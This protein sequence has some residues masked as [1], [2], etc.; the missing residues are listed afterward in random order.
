MATVTSQSSSGAAAPWRVA[1]LGGVDSTVLP[2]LVTVAT[3]LA[4]AL[5]AGAAYAGYAASVAALG[6]LGLALALGWPRALDG[7]SLPG[8]RVVL[9][10]GVLL[11]AGTM[12]AT[13]TDPRLTWLPVALAFATIGALLHQLLR[14]RDRSRLSDGM[15]AS[16]SGLAV[17][18]SGL[19][20]AA[21]AVR[22]HGPGFVLVGLVALAVGAVVELLG[23]HPRIRGLAVLPV[24]VAGGLAG[25]VTASA[26][27]GVKSGVALGLGVMVA[28]FSYSVRRVFGATRRIVEPSVQ[29][30]VAAS[31]VLLPGVLLLVMG[32][33]SAV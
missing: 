8:L 3:L 25:L 19:T 33:L 14:R 7:P 29:V 13:R 17:V 1:R 4:C 20:A 23:R 24:M 16:V 10:L 30:A 22:P 12:A 32:T 9:V 11:L 28:S 27:G 6:A 15:V 26:V 5:V 2:A 31:S 18:A 21:L